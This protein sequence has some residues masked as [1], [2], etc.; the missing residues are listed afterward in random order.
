MPRSNN[1]I[2][3]HS[4]VTWYEFKERIPIP[5]EHIDRHNLQAILDS[6]PSDRDSFNSM[7]AY[8][9]LATDDTHTS[10]NPMT[11]GQQFYD[12]P[13]LPDYIPA[14]VPA[15]LFI[16]YYYSYG[17]GGDAHL[18]R[19]WTKASELAS[20]DGQMYNRRKGFIESMRIKMGTFFRCS[21]IK[22][23]GVKT[24][25]W[26][27]LGEKEA[28]EK[29]GDKR[30]LAVDFDCVTKDQDFRDAIARTVEQRGVGLS[31]WYMPLSPTLGKR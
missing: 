7:K 14:C 28:N 9:D 23:R 22:S 1:A 17:L 27:W 16:A 5:R 12:I 25:D 29:K 31:G 10:S 3:G 19:N 20:S 4:T 18:Y 13:T 8:T 21:D 30:Y 11:M 15:I 6:I 2:V 24:R 26:Q